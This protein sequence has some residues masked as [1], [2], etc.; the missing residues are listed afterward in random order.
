MSYALIAGHYGS[1]IDCEVWCRAIG[2]GLL[3]VY[4]FDFR[5]L[6]ML[7]DLFSCLFRVCLGF[8]WLV[9]YVF[10]KM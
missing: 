1:A 4:L 2:L 8:V 3:F 10:S 7:F 5:V 6:G 9:F